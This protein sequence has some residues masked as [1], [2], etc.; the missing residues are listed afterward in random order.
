MRTQ[1]KV[2][3]RRI[4]WNLVED[5]QVWLL[6]A[7]GRS[8]RCI[9]METGLSKCQVTYRLKA[10]GIKLSD[11]RNGMTHLAEQQAAA[12]RPVTESYFREM[13]ARRKSVSNRQLKHS[14]QRRS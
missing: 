4:D 2:V 1:R 8:N 7:E 14:V 6:G 5:M 3:P 13:V 11:Y 9:Q 12:M 10:G